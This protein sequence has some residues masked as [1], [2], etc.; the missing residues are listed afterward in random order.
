ML[1]TI[2]GGGTVPPEL[3][4][5]SRLVRRGHAVRV[6]ADP[7]V[8]PGAHAARCAFSPWRRAPHVRSVEEQTALIADM[9]RRNVFRQFVFARDR[10]ICGPAKE[11]AADVVETVREDPVDAVLA[12]AAIAGILVG[13]EATRLPVA[14]LMPNIYL[15]PAPGR[16]PFGTGWAPA[17]GRAGR[18]RD[19]V[20]TEAIRRLLAT[21]L[22]A[23]N[24]ACRAY[25]LPP[26]GGL[27]ELL[28][29]C[30]RVLVMT[31]PSFDFL[32]AT[33]PSNVRYVGPQLDDP[34]WAGRGGWRPG[35]TGRL[36]LVAMSSGFQDQA[37]ALRRIAAALGRL[38]VRAVL[39]TG[40]AISPQDIPAPPNVRVLRAAPHSQVL[41][42]ADAVVT[43]AG[44]GTVL[45]ALAAGVPVVC[46]PLGRDQRDNTT[47]VLRLGAGVRISKRASA[48]QIGA[49][50]QNVLNQPAYRQAARRFAA[51]L[52]AEARGRPGAEDEAEQLVGHAARS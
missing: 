14:A 27:Y 10:I 29:R 23:V 21:G 50:V 30:T 51:T 38:P 5:A 1:A 20:A 2:D 47:R 35:G 19:A 28:D 25:H 39:T 24:T 18:I 46:M 9:E 4:L 7:T 33:L 16:P 52:A 44:H 43:H 31:S 17:R 37:Q 42:E 34:P 45:K 13:A 26:V 48:G 40:L 49:A 6:L 8:E 12:E 3:G 32:P 41:A 22:P 15:R 36:V 11:F